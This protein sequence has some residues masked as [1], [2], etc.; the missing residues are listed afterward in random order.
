MPFEISTIDQ[1]ADFL[2]AVPEFSPSNGSWIPR[3]RM[4]S[5]LALSESGLDGLRRRMRN[6]FEH[7]DAQGCVWLYAPH[8]LRG[9]GLLTEDKQNA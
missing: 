6:R 7:K 8:W 3:Q 4:A 9:W 2:G 5:T 1:L